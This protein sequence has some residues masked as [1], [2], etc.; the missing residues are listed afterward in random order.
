MK[1]KNGC[2]AKA[3][4]WLYQNGKVKDQKELSVV[5][6]ITE[7]TISRILNDRVKEPSDTTIRRLD[8]AFGN[9]FNMDFFRGK[10]VVM[11][12]SDLNHL[13]Q[14]PKESPFHEL[15]DEPVGIAAEEYRPPQV[16]PSW[17]DSLIDIMTKQ[18]KENE[19]LNMELRR[20]IDEVNGLRDDLSKLI[21]NIKRK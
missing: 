2:F 5:T 3:V 10:S 11:L 7:T 17:A 6:G 14:H 19:S 20:T 1:V 12:I 9:I 15:S 16:I 21:N 18:I 4:D 8:N 13:K